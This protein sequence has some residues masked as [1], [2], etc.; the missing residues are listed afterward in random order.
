MPKFFRKLRFWK[1]AETVDTAASLWERFLPS[2]RDLFWLLAGSAPVTAASVWLLG[3]WQAIADQGWAAV[4][5]CAI[6]LVCGVTLTISLTSLALSA[7]RRGEAKPVQDILNGI[8]RLESRISALEARPGA[9]AAPDDHL[10]RRTAA[11]ERDFGATKTFLVEAREAS[12]RNT[13]I[14]SDA[15]ATLRAETDGAKSAVQAAAEAMREE[16]AARFEMIRK[17]A[18]HALDQG[19]RR[20]K[21]LA[22]RLDDLDGRIGEYAERL[23]ERLRGVETLPARVRRL[24]RLRD[25]IERMN[26]LRNQ[27]EPLADRLLLA[28]LEDFPD[29][30]AW[31][32]A[33]KEWHGRLDGFWRLASHWDQPAFNPLAVSGDDLIGVEGV[34][35]GE[36]FK[37]YDTQQQ[38][39]TLMVAHLRHGAAVGAT[40]VRIDSAAQAEP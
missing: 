11:L 7:R 16:N 21:A 12:E 37:D 20:E 38:Y 28:R 10:A 25:E 13:T 33:Y 18:E 26:D 39:R 1:S 2:P 15:I 32:A 4:A 35:G 31:S 19:E 29:A 34:P 8:S 3:Q 23:G 14:F 40:M 17:V 6:A 24:L 5:V 36:R 27:L 30:L 9:A 22:V